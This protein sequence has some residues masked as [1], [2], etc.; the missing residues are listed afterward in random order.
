MKYIT[1]PLSGRQHTHTTIA[2]IANINLQ[3]ATYQGSAL[4]PA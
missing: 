1:L 2:N 4:A 3:E